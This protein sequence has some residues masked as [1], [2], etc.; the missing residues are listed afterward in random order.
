MTERVNTG[1]LVSFK[2]PEGHPAGGPT[3]QEARDIEEGYRE[4]DKRKKR[5]RIIKISLIV[6]LILIVMG[7]V[8]FLGRNP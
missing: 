6:V 5:N 8:G 7:L 1:G 2:Y 4:Y 3:P